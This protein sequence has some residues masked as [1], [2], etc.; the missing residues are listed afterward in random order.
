MTKAVRYYSQRRMV[1]YRGVIHVIDIGDAQA[2]TP[3]GLNWHARWNNPYGHYWPTGGCWVEAT[4]LEN[5]PGATELKAAVQNRPPLPY[6]MADRLE[7]WLLDKDR[8]LPLALLQTRLA[9]APPGKVADPTWRPFLIE[10]N[11]FSARC[12]KSRDAARN[13]Q[14]WPVPHRDVLQRQVNGAAQP[15][16]MAQ[17]F[18][19][20]A[21]GGGEGSSGFRLAPELEGRRLA[22]TDFPELL[23]REAWPSALEAE[24]VREYHEWN[25][26]QL[27]THDNLSDAT[28][29]RL[30]P[31][32]CA[33]PEKL[34]EICRLIPRFIDRQAIEVALVAAK[35]METASPGL[36]RSA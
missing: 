31:A 34:L 11:S 10:D 23:V 18:L 16:A 6:P 12:L 9:D 30:E 32:A 26:A 5:Y 33:R 35:L 21:A 8:A 27:L 19:R 15:F 7:L 24:L 1:P 20:D 25:A 4:A 13:A 36:V 22:R 14:A 28:R 17:W 3:D 2:Y 29:A